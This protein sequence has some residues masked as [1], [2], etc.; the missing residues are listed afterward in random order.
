LKL[1]F[2][3]RKG[4]SYVQC[5][6]VHPGDMMYNRF[7]SVNIN[8]EVEFLNLRGKRNKMEIQLRKVFN[9]KV[10]RE[11]KLA[12]RPIMKRF[13]PFDMMYKGS[14]WISLARAHAECLRQEIEE[15]FAKRGIE[16]CNSSSVIF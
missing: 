16:I 4:K 5:R 1:L 9:E 7:T 2:E 10:S 12:S 3:E 15:R 14:Q 13:M 11:F 8:G 6:E